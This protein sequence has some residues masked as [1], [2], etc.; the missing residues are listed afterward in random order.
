MKKWVKIIEA[1]RG[2]VAQACDCKRD[3]LWARFPFEEVKYL[4]FSFRRSGVGAKR[5]DK[6]RNASRIWQ[7]VGSGVS[8]LYSP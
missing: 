7:K 6:T 3:R 1:S 8:K 5:G 4:I 2:T